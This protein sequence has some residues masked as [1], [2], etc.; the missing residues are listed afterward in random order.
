MSGGFGC[1]L[2]RSSTNNERRTR[3]RTRLMYRPS[4]MMMMIPWQAAA[5]PPPNG[6][7]RMPYIYIDEPESNI[8]CECIYTLDAS[9]VYVSFLAGK[10]NRKEKKREKKKIIIKRDFDAQYFISA[11]L[12]RCRHCEFMSARTS[13]GPCLSHRLFIIS[14][15]SPLYFFFLFIARVYYKSL[16]IYLFPALGFF[17]VKNSQLLFR[18]LIFFFFK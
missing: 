10:K 14:F 7:N 13:L 15:S 8:D 11:G 9:V 6:L 17:F 2:G 3:R 18:S 5:P 4:P 1:P 12:R 16:V